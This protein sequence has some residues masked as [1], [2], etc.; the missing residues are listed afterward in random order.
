M[1]VRV[2]RWGTAHSDWQACD[3]EHWH[4]VPAVADHHEIFNLDSDVA[5]ELG[6]SVGLVDSGDC[7]VDVPLVDVVDRGAGR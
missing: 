7:A 1:R 3:L 2:A 6:G 5:G 4:V